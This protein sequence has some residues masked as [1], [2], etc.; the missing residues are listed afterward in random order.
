MNDSCIKTNVILQ[1]IETKYFYFSYQIRALCFVTKVVMET[2]SVTL[3]MGM[4]LWLVDTL[5]GFKKGCG[6]TSKAKSGPNRSNFS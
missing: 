2:I 5:I 4:E 1:V 6:A 3:V